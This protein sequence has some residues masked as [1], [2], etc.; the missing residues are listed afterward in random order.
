MRCV[1]HSTR[2]PSRALIVIDVQKGFDDP[3]WGPRNNPAFEENVS[4]LLE[5]FARESSPIVLVR[6]DATDPASPLHPNRPGNAFSRRMSICSSCVREAGGSLELFRDVGVEM[7]R[8]AG[9][10]AR[11]I[12]RDQP[13]D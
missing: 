4:M 10:D 6:H 3:K 11:R 8:V 13:P 9:E 5:E 2:Q 7:A 12:E 1:T